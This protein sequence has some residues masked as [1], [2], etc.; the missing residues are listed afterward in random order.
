MRP[1]AKH[2]RGASSFPTSR[3]RCRHRHRH[4]R[5]RFRCRRRGLRYQA[6]RQHAAIENGSGRL[7]PP[8]A[9]VTPGT[10]RPPDPSET[11]TSAPSYRDG[12]F[13]LYSLYCK[14]WELAMCLPLIVMTGL[15]AEGAYSCLIKTCV[16]FLPQHWA[17]GKIRN[18]VVPPKNSTGAAAPVLPKTMLVFALSQGLT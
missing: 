8:P 15:C 14:S 3:S 2:P 7:S 11:Q 9:I 1:L 13:R 5:H 6:G 12:C 10:R 16:P 4:G 18:R 17:P